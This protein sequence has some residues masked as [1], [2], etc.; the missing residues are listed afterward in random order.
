M[1]E[2]THAKMTGN[3]ITQ[4]LVYIAGIC[5][6]VL[7]HTGS[8]IDT[9]VEYHYEKFK[10]QF[11]KLKNYNGKATAYASE[12]HFR[13]QKSTNDAIIT[14][15]DIIYTALDKNVFSMGLF[16]DLR[17]TFDNVNHNYLIL[18]LHHY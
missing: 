4:R 1:E 10:K 2:T 16:I 6:N 5:L 13:S 8:N 17:M 3:M 18:K 7:I 12:F 15:F 11:P 14:L 9:I